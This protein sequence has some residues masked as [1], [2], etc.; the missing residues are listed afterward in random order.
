MDIA[1]SLPVRNRTAFFLLAGTLCAMAVLSLCIPLFT[2][3][4]DHADSS[5]FHPKLFPLYY[6]TN[7]DAPIGIQSSLGFPLFY[8]E[9]QYRV[10]RPLVIGSAAGIRAVAVPI[11]KV[12]LPK[13]AFSVMWGG[14]RAIDILS[15]YFAW[16]FLNIVFTGCAAL[17]L[18]NAFKPLFGPGVALV[19]ALLLLSA[20]ITLL[21]MREITEGSVQI[22]I[23]SASLFF[24][25]RVIMGKESLSRLLLL[26][27]GIG[28]LFTGKLAVTTFATGALL[29]LFSQ[30]R[31]NLVV[32]IPCVTLPM[33]C[34]IATIFI[35]GIPFSLNE[36]DGNKTALLSIASPSS[37]PRIL[38][39]AQSWTS[40][41]CEDG[42]LVQLP[43]AVLGYYQLYKN[44]SRLL[45]LV[46][47]FAGVDFCFF[48][49]L[50]RAHAVYGIHTMVFYFP[51]VAVGILT[52]S[53]WIVSKTR[54]SII[55]NNEPL[56][57]A[58][59]VLALQFLLIAGTIPGYGG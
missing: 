16:I 43:F 11:L 10:N 47:V 25:Q 23:A 40:V 42:L 5:I 24:W 52:L 49:A 29:C 51:A 45:W 19:A 58:M 54:I 20:P 31:K 33:L 46:P 13:K 12:L 34:W 56:V 1:S 6:Q 21:S 36:I 27:F 55:R 38:A 17:L 57:A 26:S 4:Q 59:I 30:K 8:R 48:F 32:I 35:M 53:R 44:R 41:L 3:A 50:N 9:S 14:R 18:F 28:L 2:R 22:F 15:T 39:F 7:S 37:V